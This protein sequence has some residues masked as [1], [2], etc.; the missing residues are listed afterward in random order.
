MI[1]LSRW[2]TNRDA[3]VP[4]ELTGALGGIDEH[5]TSPVDVGEDRDVQDDGR[6]QELEQ[7]L[8]HAEDALAQERLNHAARE[9][10]LRQSL[11]SDLLRELTL[12]FEKGMVELRHSIE[13][14]VADV[15]KPFLV[16]QSES[17]AMTELINLI[18][19]ELES[20]DA[21]LF[22]I[23]APIA[24]HE[25]MRPVLEERKCPAALVEGGRIELA[26]SDHRARFEIMAHR[27]RA[28]ITGGDA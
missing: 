7:A 10:E 6:E 25:R 3:E 2:L 8:R 27:W 9:E 13:C 16:T 26:F 28:I 4:T 14:A 18:D 11:G 12:Q 15:L 23:R 20:Q 17:R 21:R 24:L 22:E 19:S 5:V 1:P